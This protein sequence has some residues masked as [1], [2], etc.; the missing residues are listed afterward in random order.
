[1]TTALTGETQIPPGERDEWTWNAETKLP[2]SADVVIIGGGIVGCTAAFFLA[3]RG[4]SVLLLEKGR[5]AGEQS[6][7]NWGWVRQQ[8]RAAVELPLMQASMEIWQ[9]LAEKTGE[10]VGFVRGGCLYLAENEEQLQYYRDWVPTGDAAGLDT[11]IL[12]PRELSSVL[13]GPVQRWAGAMYTASDG[14][15]EPNRATPAIARAAV[16]AGARIISRCAA[17]G[18]ETAAGRVSGVITEHGPVAAPTVVCAAGAWTSL[19]SR[20]VGV[21]V[22]QLKVKGTV[23]RTAPARKILDGEAYSPSAAIRRR[24]DGGYTVAHGTALEHF[25][26][27]SSFRFAWKFLPALKQE[28]AGMSLRIGRDFFD[29]LVALRRWQPDRVSPFERH[30][31]L[32]P[33]PSAGILKKM[34]SDLRNCFPEI[35]GAPVLETWA[36]MI[37]TSPDV[38]PIISSVDTPDGFVV[39]TGFSGHGFGIGPGAG[40]AVADLVSG[41]VPRVDLSPFRLQRFFDGSPIRPGPTI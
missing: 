9:T 7:R 35:A 2:A 16:R 15:A 18:V 20:T 14:K 19:F 33:A 36:G 1:M 28:R 39:A 41:A 25:I 38:V 26:A 23:A 30:R 12:N 29:E 21:T 31:M 40:A 27:P 34:Q 8:G 11:R 10:D 17:R 32:S 22:P 3:R 37:E 5:V 13:I 4:V 24:A 6:G